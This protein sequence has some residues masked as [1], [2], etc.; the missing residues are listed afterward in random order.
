MFLFVAVQPPRIKTHPKTLIPNSRYL[1]N[2]NLMDTWG[3]EHAGGCESVGGADSGG[4]LPGLHG[5]L[6][7]AFAGAAGLSRPGL[8]FVQITCALTFLLVELLLDYVFHLDFRSTR[9]AAIVY[10]VLYFAACGG[11]LGLV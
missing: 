7:F 3:G 2:R 4:V 9:W 5:R 1:D 6:C 8:Y 10:V 11:L